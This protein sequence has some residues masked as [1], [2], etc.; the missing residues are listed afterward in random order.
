MSRFPVRGCGRPI[1]NV[2]YIAT[3]VDV[4][5]SSL[6]FILERSS[7][8]SFPLGSEPPDQFFYA[9]GRVSFEAE[10]IER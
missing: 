6:I 3:I 2:E 9:L 10:N 8:S 4:T 1:G 7:M 5:Y